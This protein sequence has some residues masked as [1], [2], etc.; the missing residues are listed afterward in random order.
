VG[1]FDWGGG[2]ADDV[3]TVTSGE[4]K[5]GEDDYLSLGKKRVRLADRVNS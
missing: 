2:V 3:R 4:G 5:W 1:W